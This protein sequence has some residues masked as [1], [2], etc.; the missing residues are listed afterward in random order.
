MSRDDGRTW[1]VSRLPGTGTAEV[2]TLGNRVYASVVTARGG[3]PY[4]EDRRLESV[5]RGVDGGPFESYVDEPTT[6]VGDLVPLLDDRLLLAGPDWQVSAGRGE[7]FV[8]PDGSLPWV[9][10][11][12]RTPGGWVAYNLFKDG[13]AAVSTNGTD[14]RKLTLR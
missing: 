9:Y 6:V 4:P 7:A 3:E 12:D 2:S 10:R 1:R 11:F 8:R 13:W 14:W 5:Y